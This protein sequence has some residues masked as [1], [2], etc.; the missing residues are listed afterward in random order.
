MNKIV[1]HEFKESICE[2]SV[3]TELST[4]ELA[5]CQREAS[6]VLELVIEEEERAREEAV[7]TVSSIRYTLFIGEFQPN[8]RYG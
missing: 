5:L 6:K 4:K 2:E 8:I 1:I 3:S 7:I